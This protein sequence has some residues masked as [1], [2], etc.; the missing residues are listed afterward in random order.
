M[1]CVCSWPNQY[2]NA[3][4][5]LADNSKIIISLSDKSGGIVIINTDMH[6]K[7]MTMLWVDNKSTR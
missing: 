5:K 1:P 7:E 2:I 4:S 6:Q 3:L